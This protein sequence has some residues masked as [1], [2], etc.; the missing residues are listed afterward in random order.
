MSTLL[1]SLW[2]YLAAAGAALLVLWRV[3]AGAKKAGVDQQKAK[4]LQAREQARRE[5][6]NRIKDA[7]DAGA[8]VQPLRP[9][10]PN[11]DPYDLDR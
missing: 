3:L 8:R 1:A 5:E 4:E 10:V 6:L 9:G 11:D 2:P 7:T